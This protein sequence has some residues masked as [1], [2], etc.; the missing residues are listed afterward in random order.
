MIRLRTSRLWAQSTFL[1][2]AGTAC[3]SLHHGRTH[4]AGFCVSPEAGADA[5]AIS[6]G[7]RAFSNRPDSA[8]LP[9]VVGQAL[10]GIWDVLTVT[11]EGAAPAEVE[12]WR[13]RLVPT[14]R[15]VWYQCMFGPCRTQRVAVVAAG[16]P[17]R[18]HAT[19]DSSA[20]AQRRSTDPA[21]IEAHYDSS[22]KHLTLSFGPPMLDAGTFYTVTELSDTLLAGRWTDGS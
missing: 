13:L 15:G 11:T 12:R 18:A 1:F 3:T 9:A 4:A 6:W 7:A 19:F 10:A 5:G 21:R 22:T 20:S 2:I 14:D 16:A 8:P 17:L